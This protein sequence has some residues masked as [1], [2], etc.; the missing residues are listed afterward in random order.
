[1]GFAKKFKTAIGAVADVI[2]GANRVINTVSGLPI[3]TGAIDILKSGVD[4][5]QRNKAGEAQMADALA[6]QQAATAEQARLKL[7][8]D[9]SVQAQEE[10][11]RKKTVFGG[12]AQQ[13]I[14]ERRKLLGI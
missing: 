11:A 2:P 4:Q 6:Q 13:Q 14:L 3:R 12:S 8:A 7:I 1:M 5:V 10:E 9:A